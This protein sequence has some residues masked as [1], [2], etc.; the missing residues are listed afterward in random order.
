[1]WNSVFH[2]GNSWKM[3]FPQNLWKIIL[4]VD[5]FTLGVQL[6]IFCRGSKK[7]DAVCD[8]FGI[9]PIILETR[10]PTDDVNFCDRQKEDM[11]LAGY[12]IGYFYGRAFFVQGHKMR[13][14]VVHVGS[15]KWQYYCCSSSILVRFLSGLFFYGNFTDA[16]LHSSFRDHKKNFPKS[17]QKITKIC[18]TRK[19]KRNCRQ[20]SGDFILILLNSTLRRQSFQVFLK[21][22]RCSYFY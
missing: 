15:I 22:N 10:L 17:Q 8:S 5:E 11:L 14:D 4:L 2:I 21:N 13:V 20:M 18:N 1:M 16:I 3:C 19:S 9:G 7:V 6:R 12:V